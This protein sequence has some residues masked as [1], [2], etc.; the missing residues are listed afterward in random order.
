MIITMKIVMTMTTTRTMEIMRSATRVSFHILFPDAERNTDFAMFGDSGIPPPL[1]LSAP[2]LGG[3][4]PWVTSPLRNAVSS[5][6]LLHE[7]AMARFYQ[8][9]A[10]E[11][12]EKAKQRKETL[13]RKSAEPPVSSTE[14]GRSSRKVPA[15]T[16][17]HSPMQELTWHQRKQRTVQDRR[18]SL[19]A[20][21]HVTR[22]FPQP[23]FDMK[24]TLNQKKPPKVPY[25]EEENTKFETMR[26]ETA[27][28]KYHS[29]LRHT[30]EERMKTKAYEEI[31]ETEWKAILQEEDEEEVEDE[32]VE[33]EEVEEE[34][35]EVE[36]EEEELGEES[37]GNEEL[38][39][40]ESS[41]EDSEFEEE[42]ELYRSMEEEEEIYHPDSTGTRHIE[43]FAEQEDDTY[44]PS[45]VVP[46]ALSVEVPRARASERQRTSRSIDDANAALKSILKHNNK[47]Q[48]DLEDTRHE[49]PVRELER[50]PPKSFRESLPE[51]LVHSL[52]SDRRS[53]LRSS[54]LEPRSPEL[55]QPV[56]QQV[57]SAEEFRIQNDIISIPSETA[58]FVQQVASSTIISRTSPTK[59]KSHIAVPIVSATERTMHTAAPAALAADPS[60][61]KPTLINKSSVED[62]TEASRA[63]AD[64]YGDI[65][66]DHA[67]PK[68]LVRQYL[69]TAEMKAAAFVSQNER[70]YLQTTSVSASRT[71]EANP[72]IERS[73]EEEAVSAEQSAHNRYTAE[74]SAQDRYTAEQSAHDRYTASVTAEQSS[75]DRYSAP[76]AIEQSSRDRYSAPGATEQSSRDRYTAPGAAENISRDRHA[77]S[78]T[79][80]ESSRGRYT[81]PGVAEKS[82][83][84]RYTAQGTAQKSSRDRYTAPGKAEQ[85]SSDRYTA[86]GRAEKSSRD[87]YTASGKAEQGSRDRYTV[88]G[89]AEKSSRDRYT[90]PVAAE[91]SERDRSTSP[92]TTKKTAYDR[93]TSPSTTKKTARD[94]STSPS[95]TKK[96]AYDRYTGPIPAE[97]RAY[98]R[99]TTPVQQPPTRC[100]KSRTP[101]L[102]RSRQSSR[103]RSRVPST[104]RSLSEL[105]RRFPDLE[106][107]FF[108][109]RKQPEEY[110]HFL[111]VFPKQ[112]EQL[113]VARRKWRSV[114]GYL[115]DLAMFLVACWLYAFKDERLA[116]PVLVLMVYRQL[117]KAIRRRLPKLPALPWKRSS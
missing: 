109:E 67:R 57:Q 41:E 49:L 46:Y 39:E 93:S 37:Y 71:P 45:G 34:D 83:R 12:A 59:Q 94:R 31:Q 114:V 70:E 79:A 24:S 8:A 115:A 117:Q 28:T 101:D 89:T 15:K 64:Y 17:E 44:H 29:T 26:I 92:S 58:P 110:E 113:Q 61:K 105:P 63:V 88:P 102:V 80:E 107:R 99:C 33:E 6:E 65:I 7:Q 78:N 5:T 55:P 21:S 36:E 40:E 22:E 38:E 9:V 43:R 54:P 98:D 84:D 48:E 1:S 62:D 32:E 27:E 13:N 86:S 10:A 19:E 73:A 50:S 2:E 47:F 103:D 85:S 90:A 60:K 42:E 53:H 97:Q 3:G 23:E 69:N 76:G 108:P 104:E 77:A 111:P 66:R 95:T 25:E 81:A 51:E 82:S 87:R 106:N 20:A 35:E 14:N 96:T 30:V 16:M 56:E 91:Q 52:V 18:L 116:I 75:R 68:K 72:E 11:E 74:Q 100:R 112:D 4:E